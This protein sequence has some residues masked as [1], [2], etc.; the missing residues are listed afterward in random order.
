VSYRTLITKAII[1]SAYFA[2][3][4]IAL[5]GPSFGDTSREVKAIGKDIMVCV[6]LSESMNAADIQPPGLKR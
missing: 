4:I 3:F 5:L 6:D 2:L 1:R